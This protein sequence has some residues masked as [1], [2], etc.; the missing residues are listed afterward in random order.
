[1][2]NGRVATVSDK[3]RGR[4]ESMFGGNE[5]EKNIHDSD[6]SLSGL[7]RDYLAARQTSEDAR[8]VAAEANEREKHIEGDLIRRMAEAGVKSIKLD[9]GQSIAS[10]ATTDYRL[11]PEAEA[12]R[13]EDVIRWLRH[14]RGGSLVKKTVA[15]QSFSAWCRERATEGK[16]MHEGVTV[17]ERQ[18]I[19]VRKGE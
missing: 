6:S 16:P 2:Q 11:P 7:A 14:C 1:M 19:S 4:L 12:T 17:A 5:P 13:R 15:W 8:K 10:V 18:Y 3:K 9:E